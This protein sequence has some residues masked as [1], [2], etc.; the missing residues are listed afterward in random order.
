[1]LGVISHADA[2]A[3]EAKR[4]SISFAGIR[5]VIAAGVAV[6]DSA[7]ELGVLAVFTRWLPAAAAGKALRWT[8][9]G[10]LEN[11]DFPAGG[12]AGT[13]ITNGAPDYAHLG[14]PDMNSGTFAPNAAGGTVGGTPG[15]AVADSKILFV[16]HNAEGAV[17]FLNDKVTYPTT[18][19]PPG[20]AY[21]AA[22]GE[23]TL[24][25][26]GDENS[27]WIVCASL[28]LRA[29]SAA[30][31]GGDRVWVRGAI[32]HGDNERH[33]NQ[34][35][36]RYSDLDGDANQAGADADEAELT[37]EARLSI[38]GSVVADGVQKTK[39]Q[40]TAFS[41][42]VAQANSADDP[43]ANIAIVGAHVHAYRITDASGSV[44][45]GKLS[46]GPRLD[47]AANQ[48]A[49][50]SHRFDVDL[51]DKTGLWAPSGGNTTSSSYIIYAWRITTDDDW[52][53]ANSFF[54][55]VDN[56]GFQRSTNGARGYY[57]R[58]T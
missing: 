22:T 42:N 31:G 20:A 10:K 55:E 23:L 14:T 25:K 58:A 43:N 4:G 37:N 3:E 48:N 53:F 57:V 36:I 1:M 56:N 49:L 11:V 47:V 26:T 28:R 13:P 40:V 45:V 8:A 29:N 2:A 51:S 19:L 39:I 52:G 9:G 18:N 32:F 16:D 27:H 33:S 34:T 6:A 12:G 7:L 50:N 35:Y 5:N 41:Q 54:S 15:V 30:G 46:F 38:T 44:A 17:K 21:D 24:P